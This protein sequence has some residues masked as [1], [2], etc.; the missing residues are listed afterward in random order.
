[1]KVGSPRLTLAGAQLEGLEFIMEGLLGAV[2]GYRLPGAAPGDWPVAPT[3]TVA[4]ALAESAIEAGSL[5]L[6][7]PDTTPIAHLEVQA[8]APNG[9]DDVWLSG[10]VQSLRRPEHAPARRF[11]LEPDVDLSD[12]CVALFAGEVRAADVIRALR[13]AGD[14]PLELVVVGSADQTESLRMLRTLEESSHLLARSNVRFIPQIDVGDSSGVDIPLLVLATCGAAE[15]LDL[16]REDLTQSRGAVVLLTGLSGS[17]KS[18]VARALTDYLM[19]HST[20][21]V[22]LLDGDHVRAE[23]ASELGFSAADRDRNLQRQAW[24]AARVAQAGGLAVCAPIAPFAAT[25][26]AMRAKVEPDA[27]FLLVHVSTPLAVAEQRDRKGLYAKAR[28]GLIKDFT[29][30]DSPYEIPEDADLVI[31]TSVLSVDACVSEI[32][33]MLAEAGLMRG[34]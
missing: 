1:M 3:L 24:V 26:A 25:R 23:L 5:E 6:C 31:D 16:R 2:D 17:G 33:R 30:I 12:R 22:V 34:E 27:P 8:S 18:T 11:R 29:G 20:H 9:A 19:A 32:V 14:A 28:A 4:R 15:L 21:R 10:P 13:A 7:D